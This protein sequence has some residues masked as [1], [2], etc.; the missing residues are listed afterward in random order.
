[1]TWTV[2][3]LTALVFVALLGLPPH[4][5]SATEAF[6]GA[7]DL[8]GWC[9]NMERDDIHWGLCVGSITAAHDIIMTYQAQVDMEQLVCTS[10]E[11]TRGDV[12][13]AVIAYMNEHPEE[14]DYSLGD[15]ITS[16][17]M[18]KFPCP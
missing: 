10:D 5:A 6:S 9:A 16:A 4:P 2:R 15:V 12:V 14:Q 7:R 13:N 11:T 1:M 18:D 8:T 17:L 3:A